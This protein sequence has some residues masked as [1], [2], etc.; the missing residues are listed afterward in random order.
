M[1]AQLTYAYEREESTVLSDDAN[2]SQ[3]GLGV[4]LFG[5]IFSRA[6]PLGTEGNA[7]DICMDR[8]GPGE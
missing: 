5:A 8:A 6:G 3:P 7:W 1:N 4:R 2:R